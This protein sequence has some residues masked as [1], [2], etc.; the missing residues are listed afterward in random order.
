MASIYNFTIDQGSKFQRLMTW[1]DE[2]K[3]IIDLTGYTARLEAKVNVGDTTKVLNMTTV[4]LQIVLLPGLVADHI[5]LVLKATVTDDLDFHA[6]NYN[7]EMI[8][9]S[10]EDDVTR[11]LQGRVNL[12]KEVATS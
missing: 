11:L 9:P 10:G 5:E 8:P 7:L 4:N 3:V 1:K 6:A 12:N 2:N